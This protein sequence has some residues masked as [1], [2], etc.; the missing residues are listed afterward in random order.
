[1]WAFSNLLLLVSCFQISFGDISIQVDFADASDFENSV[2]CD[3]FEDLSGSSK[4]TIN[5]KLSEISDKMFNNFDNT[6]V[7]SEIP[8]TLTA[9][10]RAYLRCAVEPAGPHCKYIRCKNYTF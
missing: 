4:L 10:D 9:T 6:A 5:R 2:N 3:N 1:M 7:D 8:Y